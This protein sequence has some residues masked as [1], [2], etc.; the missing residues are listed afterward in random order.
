[1]VSAN[2]QHVEGAED[3]VMGKREDAYAVRFATRCAAATTVFWGWL[4]QL[5]VEGGGMS[6]IT[7]NNWL[8]NESIGGSNKR[9]C[10]IVERGRIGETSLQELSFGVRV[11]NDSRSPKH[12]KCLGLISSEESDQG[13][14]RRR[15]AT[16]YKG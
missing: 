9:T 16:C 7:C 14:S 8:L 6:G 13:S 10:I 12:R 15:G 1:M 4:W 5:W 11:T 3:I 2:G